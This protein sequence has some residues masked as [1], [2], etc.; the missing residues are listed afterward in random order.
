MWRLWK[1]RLRRAELRRY[2]K[3]VE[4]ALALQRR[5]EGRRDGLILETVCNSMQV[6]WRARRMHPWDRNLPNS[7]RELAFQQQTLADIE[8]AILRLFEGLPQ[9]DVLQVCVLEPKSET[10]IAEGAV[11]RSALAEVRALLSVGMRLRD[12]GLRY[13]FVQPEERYAATVVAADERATDAP[14]PFA[15]KN[16]NPRE[17]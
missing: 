14:A 17:A 6:R 10:V 2:K 12:L 15:G 11:H 7:E 13:P 9:I 1:Q 8:A 3:K 5:G 4:G 16:A